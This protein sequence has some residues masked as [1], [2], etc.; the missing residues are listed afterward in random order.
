MDFF[1]FFQGNVSENIAIK[2]RHLVVRSAGLQEAPEF[3]GRQASC[4]R[5]FPRGLHLAASALEAKTKVDVGWIVVF[6]APPKTLLDISLRD[7]GVNA[8]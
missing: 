4:I 3:T 2:K 8:G 7:G 5:A 6:A 1:F